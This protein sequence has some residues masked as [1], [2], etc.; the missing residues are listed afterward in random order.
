MKDATLLVFK[1]EE[2]DRA[3][4]VDDVREFEASRY[5]S[6]LEHWLTTAD[7][8]IELSAADG[9]WPEAVV[10]KWEGHRLDD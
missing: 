8:V 3:F 1:D 5:A 6:L 2:H 9:E 10:V 7:V 4:I